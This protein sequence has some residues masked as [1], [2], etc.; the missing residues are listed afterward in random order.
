M[1]RL[2]YISVLLFVHAKNSAIALIQSPV[3]SNNG[4]PGHGGKAYL[5]FS[6]FWTSR[7]NDATV[8]LLSSTAVLSAHDLRD[9]AT[10]T[11]STKSRSTSTRVNRKP[12]VLQNSCGRSSINFR[13][14]D[15][16]SSIF[17]SGTSTPNLTW[18]INWAP[19]LLLALMMR[20][21]AIA[22]FDTVA[23]SRVVSDL[24][25]VYNREMSAEASSNE[26]KSA[27]RKSKSK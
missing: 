2:F 25:V 8:L 27:Q 5:T 22:P 21:L 19:P 11:Y 26:G 9:C 16:K 1:A 7:Q 18:I 4:W 17:D 24:I 10:T 20:H 6:F 23:T 13:T 14:A 12:T 15:L 3:A